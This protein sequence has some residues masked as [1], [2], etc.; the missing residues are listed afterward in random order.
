MVSVKSLPQRRLF[1]S[2]LLYVSN[3]DALKGRPIIRVRRLICPRTKKINGHFAIEGCYRIEVMEETLFRVICTDSFSLK[4]L[5]LL[6]Q[7]ISVSEIP[8][9][10][11]CNINSFPKTVTVILLKMYVDKHTKREV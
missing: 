11:C 1:L 3:F 6:L 10:Y 2:M 4:R 5:L 9:P 7:I 8:D